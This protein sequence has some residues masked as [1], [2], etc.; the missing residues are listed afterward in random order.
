MLCRQYVYRSFSQKA[1][2]SQKKPRTRTVYLQR[3]RPC[4]LRDV[5]AKCIPSFSQKARKSQKKPRTR[6][7]YLQRIR[8]CDLRDLRANMYTKFLAEGAE[9]AE[10]AADKDGLPSAYSSV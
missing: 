9:D 4:D 2:K 3:I 1:R 5:R 10:E 8:P 6:T 7:V